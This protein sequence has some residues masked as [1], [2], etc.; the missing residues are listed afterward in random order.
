MSCRTRKLNSHFSDNPFLLFFVDPPGVEPGSRVTLNFKGITCFFL[1]VIGSPT[2]G[3]INLR[4]PP[5]SLFQGA[6]FPLCYAAK[7]TRTGA[8]AL[9]LASIALARPTNTLADSGVAVLPL[10]GFGLSR[11]PRLHAFNL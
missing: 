6:E 11:Q 3:Q 1:G 7:A 5:L 10:T 4:P 8:E 9:S 2:K